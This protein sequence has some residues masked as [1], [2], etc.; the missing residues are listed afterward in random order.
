MARS[1][2]PTAL[3]LKFLGLWWS[4]LQRSVSAWTSATR[5]PS[6]GLPD[7]GKRCDPAVKAVRNST[8]RRTLVPAEL[9]A[10]RPARCAFLPFNQRHERTSDSQVRVWLGRGRW[11]RGVPRASGD[12]LVAGCR[13]GDPVWCVR[14]RDGMTG[15]R[16]KGSY[17]PLV[18]AGTDFDDGRM[19]P[20]QARPTRKPVSAPRVPL[21]TGLVLL[22]GLREA[23]AVQNELQ[24]RALL[25]QEPSLE[26][27]LHWS[28]D[29]E[30]WRLH[31]SRIPKSDGRR[32]SVT[33]SGWCPH[34]S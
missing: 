3:G 16:R 4:S 14:N 21:D 29:G 19:I 31:G 33:R 2:S 22:R 6:L 20:S 11:Y 12:G 13:M 17:L 34:V 9:S 18:G 7:S 32:R 24:E 15:F 10:Q 25:R 23:H 1:D 30:E 8:F 5:R 26:E 27:F 28:Y